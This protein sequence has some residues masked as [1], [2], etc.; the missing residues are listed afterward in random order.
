MADVGVV[1]RREWSG[2]RGV[3]P[4]VDTTDCPPP[5]K[6]RMA[7]ATLR[8]EPGMEVDAAER[9]PVLLADVA[10]LYR[11]LQIEGRK[12]HIAGNKQPRGQYAAAYLALEAQIYE[13]SRRYW[14]SAVRE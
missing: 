11:R 8:P 6:L 13:A 3:R 5:P 9:D 2:F 4:P 10:R 7:K 12:A 1:M 14:A